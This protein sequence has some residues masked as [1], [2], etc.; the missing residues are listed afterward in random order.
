VGL[1]ESFKIVIDVAT[2]GAQKSLKQLRRDVIETDGAFG[3]MKV[4]SSGALDYLKQNAA[5]VALTAGTALVTFGVKSVQA[6][7]DTALAAGSFSASTGIAVED[8]SRLI[9]V[10]GDLGISSTDVEGSFLKLSK[11]LGANSE[12]LAQYGVEV[13][14]AKDGT[15]DANATFINAVTTIGK[16]EDSTKRTEAAQR[17]S[18]GTSSRSPS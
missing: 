17:R 14:R 11:T 16:I 9:E 1:R 15:I 4:A 7:Q 3:K 12:A 8:A 5:A 10:A 13:V 18:A 6:F 2:D